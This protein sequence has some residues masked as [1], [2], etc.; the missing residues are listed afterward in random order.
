MW[1]LLIFT[2]AIQLLFSIWPT[3]DIMVSGTFFQSDGT[4]WLAESAL[5]ESL[6]IPI[7]LAS[8]AV[9]IMASV[10]LCISLSRGPL[11]KTPWRLWAFVTALYV[12]GPGL[13]VNGLLK[14]NWGRARPDAVEAFGGV[15]LFTPPFEMAGQCQ[16]NCSF[17]SGEAASAAVMAIVLATIIGSKVA[18]PWRG[19][20]FVGLAGLFIFASGMRVASGRHFLSD[21]VFAGLFMAMIARLLYRVF[22]IATVRND[23]LLSA[24]WGDILDVT[25]AVRQ[26]VGRAFASIG[27]DRNIMTDLPD[28]LVEPVRTK[29]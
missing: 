25:L 24:A 26:A 5:A 13:L 7:W 4:F 12:I 28:T 21:A 23:N 20:M 16:F 11:A 15:K 19:L 29:A 18:K 22:G 8:V 17:V 6:R 2:V 9:A 14:Q 10:M 1:Q 3:V 27:A